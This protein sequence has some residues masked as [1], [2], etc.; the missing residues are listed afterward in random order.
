MGL[1]LNNGLPRYIMSVGW[2]NQKNLGVYI[3]FFGG[4]VRN[5]QINTSQ[6]SIEYTE[7]YTVFRGSSV[8]GIRVF[9]CSRKI[10]R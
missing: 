1:A 9:P 2:R 6:T 3:F 10:D 8:L 7:N 5:A 4:G